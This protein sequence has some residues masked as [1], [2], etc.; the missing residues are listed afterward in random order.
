MK[1]KIVKPAPP[2]CPYNE[3]VACW[4]NQRKCPQCGWNPEVAEK[5]LKDRN[6]PNKKVVVNENRTD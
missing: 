5:R 4:P 1:K 6:T 3:G 2:V